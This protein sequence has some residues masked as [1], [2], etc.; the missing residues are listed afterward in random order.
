MACAEAGFKWQLR[1]VHSDTRTK[2]VGEGRE[3]GLNQVLDLNPF[4][5]FRTSRVLIG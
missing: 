5:S 2:E 4:H 3:L 1:T